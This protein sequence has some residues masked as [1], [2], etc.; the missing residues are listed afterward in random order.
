MSRRELLG[1][2]VRLML[3][4]VAVSF[5]MVLMLSLD[6]SPNGQSDAQS[7]SS[8]I[9]AE[10]AQ[11]MGLGETR[12]RRYRDQRVWV[13]R[14]DSNLRQKLF[15]LDKVIPDPSQGCGA[16][17]DLCV[18][19]A[20][21]LQDGIEIVYSTIAPPQLAGHLPWYGGF[22]NPR[23]GNTYDLLGRAYTANALAL[24]IVE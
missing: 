2:L 13:T 7:G 19:A 1:R 24:T 11:G 5:F 23:T 18:V 8:N 10:L 4:L 16:S 6:T 12:M 14:L 9:R 17:Q 22:V 21:T 15:L 3:L 20:A